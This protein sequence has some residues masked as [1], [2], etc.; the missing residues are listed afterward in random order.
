MELAGAAES[1]TEQSSIELLDELDRVATLGWETFKVSPEYDPTDHGTSESDCWVDQIS[2]D[3]KRPYPWHDDFLFLAITYGLRSFVACKLL[4]GHR[5]VKQKRGRPYLHY[6]IINTLDN[7]VIVDPKMVALLFRYG[8]NPNQMAG[9]HWTV[10]QDFLVETMLSTS[11]DHMAAIQ[12]QIFELFLKHGADPNTFCE[13][14]DKRHTTVKHCVSEVV[15]I[16]LADFPKDVEKILTLLAE[17]QDSAVE[18]KEAKGRR[19]ILKRL[20]KMVWEQK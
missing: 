6:A 16:V 20:R 14:Y 2:H 5:V 19:G 17:R 3:Y 13:I 8:A 11:K 10:W 12:V 4:A 1:A 15:K 7:P 18:L 9:P